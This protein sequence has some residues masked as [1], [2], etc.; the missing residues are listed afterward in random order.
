MKRGSKTTLA[1]S[2]RS[3]RHKYKYFLRNGHYVKARYLK[4]YAKT[5][6]ELLRG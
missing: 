2:L 6:A 4:R 3:V 5:H 1:K